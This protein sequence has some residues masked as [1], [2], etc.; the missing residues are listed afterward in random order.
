MRCA[1]RTTAAWAQFRSG[2]T[3]N[4][5]R[6]GPLP[7][8]RSWGEPSDTGAI[9]YAPCAALIYWPDW[10]GIRMYGRTSRARRENDVGS[11]RSDF[12]S[13]MSR[14]ATGL[15]TRICEAR[16]LLGWSQTVLTQEASFPRP[17]IARVELG[18]DVSMV[19]IV[20]VALLSERALSSLDVS[21]FSV[22]ARTPGSVTNWRVDRQSYTALT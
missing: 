9:A 6:L 1:A 2:A 8:G 5:P 3:Q 12:V 21:E 7:I 15:G 4:I 18:I 20:K 16:T 19:T 17:V 22:V 13:S 10:V 14:A 11:A